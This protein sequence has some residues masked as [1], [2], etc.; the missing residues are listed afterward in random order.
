M[1]LD[2]LDEIASFEAASYFFD[3]PCTG[4]GFFYPD[5][6]LSVSTPQPSL[7]PGP[8]PNPHALSLS[9]MLAAALASCAEIRTTFGVKFFWFSLESVSYTTVLRVKV[10]KTTPSLLSVGR[11]RVGFIVLKLKS[12]RAFTRGL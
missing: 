9:T 8:D 6:I 12:F 2:N 1:P 5:R 4:E 11:L 7:S 10:S 3:S